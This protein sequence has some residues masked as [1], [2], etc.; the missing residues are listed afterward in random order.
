MSAPAF[1][2]YS[3][4]QH[5]YFAD[6]RELK[7]VT[8]ILDAAGMISPYC[9]DEEARFRGTKVHEYCAIDDETPIDLRTIPAK[10]RGYLRAWRMFRRDTGFTPSLIEHRVDCVDHGYSGRF[11]RLGYTPGSIGTVL[12]IKTSKTGAVPDYARL[13]L[14]AYGFAFDRQRVFARTAVSLKPD[15]TYNSRNY[16][17]TDYFIDRAEWL[18]TVKTQQEKSNGH[19]HSNN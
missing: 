10:F 7:S 14:V 8:Q 13:Q 18:S 2:E 12:D 4:E 16:P 19:C 6:G 9:K 3:D 17:I 15:G 5:R 11:D 1:L